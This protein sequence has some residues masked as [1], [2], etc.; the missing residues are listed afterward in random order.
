MRF[1]EA[2]IAAGIVIA[3]LQIFD[4]G[5]AAAPAAVHGAGDRAR[6]VQFVGDFFHGGEDFRAR[7]T[8]L[9]AFLVAHTPDDNGGMV[10][11]ANY[12]FFEVGKVIGGVSGLVLGE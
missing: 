4:V 11:V 1:V 6:S 7:F 3:A 8:A 10:A 9:Y 5:N 12:H 2:V